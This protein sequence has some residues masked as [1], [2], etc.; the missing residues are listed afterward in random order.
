[1]A[2]QWESTV[3]AGVETLKKVR[4]CAVFARSRNYIPKLLPLLTEEALAAKS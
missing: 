1:M 3:S 2:T 4:S